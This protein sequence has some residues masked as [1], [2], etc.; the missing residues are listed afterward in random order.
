MEKFGFS[1]VLEG[2]NAKAYQSFQTIPFHYQID[3]QGAISELRAPRSTRASKPLVF[4]IKSM[5]WEAFLSLRPSELANIYI[6]IE[7]ERKKERK[8]EAQQTI[9]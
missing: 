5:L 9:D 7:R 8:N 2:L 4:I 6:Y 1:N 3:A